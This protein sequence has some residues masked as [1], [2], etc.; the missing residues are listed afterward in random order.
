MNKGG[1]PPK[2]APMDVAFAKEAIRLFATTRE[3]AIH[4]RIS[5]TSMR[6]YLKGECRQHRVARG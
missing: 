6:R 3:M 1:R 5:E 2:L 4:F